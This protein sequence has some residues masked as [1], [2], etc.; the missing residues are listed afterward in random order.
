[1]DDVH[2]L[3]FGSKQD[4]RIPHSDVEWCA[5]GMV[6]FKPTIMA[7]EVVVMPI[8]EEA[9]CANDKGKVSFGS[10]NE[11]CDQEAGISISN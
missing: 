1:M 3:P 10:E 8:Y 11:I 6:T 5:W 4:E 2:G 7:R 9:I